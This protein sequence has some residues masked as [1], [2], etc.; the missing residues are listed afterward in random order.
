MKN[1]VVLIG[2][3][4]DNVKMHHF[5]G[6]GCL[7]RFPLA[8]SSSYT[9]KQTGEKVKET[10]WHTCIVRNKQAEV[11]EKY[12]KKG[13]QVSV[14]GSIRYR[15]WTDNAG[16]EK[17]STEIIISDFTFLT[18]NRSQGQSAAQQ[19]TPQQAAPKPQAGDDAEPDDLP[20]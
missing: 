12:V 7:G 6:G 8:T 19:V 17:Y 11:F 4:G 5:E 13:D 16:V 1:L 2:N 9:N 20:F 3:T 10:Q 18:N 15:K 14:Q